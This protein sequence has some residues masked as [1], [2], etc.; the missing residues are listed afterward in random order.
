MVDDG[1]SM[2]ILLDELE[3]LRARQA[4]CEDELEEYRAGRKGACAE[5]DQ[6]REAREKLGLAN[7]IVENSPA[8][9]FRRKADD[10]Y[11]L[12][13]VSENVS[14]WGYSAKDF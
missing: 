3:D 7:L 5:V 14:Q 13:Y 4:E 12:V 9:L 8:V 11:A 10:T 1:V 6:L 2:K